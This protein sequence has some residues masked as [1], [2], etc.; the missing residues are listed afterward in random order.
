MGVPRENDIRSVEDVD[1]ELRLLAAVRW[2]I[3]QQG[4]TST[5]R[6]VDE[7]LDERSNASDGPA[8]T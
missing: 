5:T 7:L 6:H 2:S 1:Q 8:T 3:T 4:G